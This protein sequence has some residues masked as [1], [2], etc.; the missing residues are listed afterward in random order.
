MSSDVARWCQKCER[1]QVANDV[2]PKAHGFMGNLLASC[3]NEILAINYTTLEPA[4]NGVENVLVHIDVFS[5]YTVAVPTQN[6]HVV[7]VARVLLSEVL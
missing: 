5:K 4:Q 1:C 2:H 7:T 6:Q 3:P